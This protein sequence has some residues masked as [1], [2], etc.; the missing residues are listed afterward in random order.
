M[1]RVRCP[2]CRAR[3]QVPDD[4]PGLVR[5][6]TCGGIVR[7]KG[8]PFLEQHWQASTDTE[9]LLS[10]LAAPP[11]ERK[12]R[13][14]AVACCRL[15][16]HVRANTSL[17]K[18]VAVAERRADGAAT[19]VEVEAAR[20]GL[21]LLRSPTLEFS[22]YSAIDAV[23]RLVQALGAADI[24][25]ASRVANSCRAAF[26]GGGG[27]AREASTAAALLRDVLGNPFRPPAWDPSWLTWGA[28]TVP[29]LAQEIYE[30][31]YFDRLPILADALEEAG[32]TDAEILGH[33]RCPGVH[34]RGC[35]VVDAA[36][37]LD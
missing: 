10:S 25:W 7:V 5:C 14:F 22:S 27:G 33:C 2:G 21:S 37:G 23:R 9:I 35:W 20:V 31:G 28:A 17:E 30:S 29:R 4:S 18:A 3:F 34:V 24:V 11:S 8:R 19:E 32:C 12:L 36:R 16:W 6:P 15:L 13:L 26:L 1:I